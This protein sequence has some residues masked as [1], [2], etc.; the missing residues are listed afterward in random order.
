M[1]DYALYTGERDAKEPAAADFLKKLNAHL[2]SHG[3]TAVA[4]KIV[5]AGDR[6]KHGSPADK[7]FNMIQSDPV[8]ATERADWGAFCTA[9]KERFKGAT[10]ISKPAAQLEAELGRMR[11]EMG[12]LAKGSI[13]VGDREV[14]VLADFVERVHDAVA[15]VDA[16]AKNVGMWDFYTALPAVLQEAIGG[17]VPAS[18]SAMTTAL[19]RVP[20][21]KV[22]VAAA[23]YREQKGMA[24][25]VDALQRKLASMSMAASRITPTAPRVG[26][27]PA[28]PVA[29]SGTP[30]APN[31]PPLNPPAPATPAAPVAPANGKRAPLTKSQ[32]DLLLVV[33]RECVRRT[34]PDTPVGRAGYA[35]DIALWHEKYRKVPR[36]SLQLEITGYPLSPGIAPPCSG[37]CWRCGVATSPSHTKSPAGCAPRAELPA[38]E[39]TLRALAGTWLGRVD[40]RPPGAV[41]AVH[42]VEVVKLVPWYEGE[43]EA[44]GETADVAEGFVNGLQ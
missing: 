14:Y 13:Q 11:I 21:S 34:R 18:W 39:T 24:E 37:E 27:N 31:P 10:P 33:L 23:Q 4:E 20:Q 28:P 41:A 29:S 36:S 44:S 15:D 6:F 32:K 7:W 16:G 2:R 12:N 30:N 42:V 40:L 19:S 26:P 17:V 8:K 35:Q 22:E 3:V 38:L 43:D 5:E 25:Q 9:F 1:A